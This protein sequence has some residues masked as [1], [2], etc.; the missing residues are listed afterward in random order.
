MQGIQYMV[1]EKGE[2]TAVVIDLKQWGNLWEDIQ[3]ILVSASRKDEETIDWN[4]LKN[5]T[6]TDT[7][8]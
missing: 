7:T 3:D 8:D 5:E 6:T 2:K 1:D 4:T